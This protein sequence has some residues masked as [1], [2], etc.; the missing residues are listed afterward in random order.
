MK[1]INIGLLGIIGQAYN[2]HNVTILIKITVMFLCA[3]VWINMCHYLIIHKN[4]L[5]WHI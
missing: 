1:F 5:F 3:F 4:L 2:K